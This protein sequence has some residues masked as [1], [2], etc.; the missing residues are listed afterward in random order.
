MA[1]FFK[2]Y[3]TNKTLEENGVKVFL[4]DFNCTIKVARTKNKKHLEL[5]KK[6][7]KPFHKY[8]KNGRIV[9]IPADVEK[10][11]EEITLRIWAETIL[12]G[13]EGIEVD[14]KPFPY[15][16]DN[17][18]RLL[19]EDDFFAQVAEAAGNAETFRN[20]ELEDNSK[21]LKKAS[22]GN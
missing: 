4:P 22:S 5:T 1:D 17:A 12:L 20:V 19:S 14:D 10:Q 3:C 9:D 2:D 6:L 11:I 21:N 13:W 7:M 18:V 8:Q 15:S 16:I